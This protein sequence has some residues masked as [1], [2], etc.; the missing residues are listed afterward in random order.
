MN[1]ST[2]FNYFIN[3]DNTSMIS[4]SL[5][6]SEFTN[7]NNKLPIIVKTIMANYKYTSVNC[8]QNGLPNVNRN[9]KPRK[10]SYCTDFDL[11]LNNFYSLIAY[12][13]CKYLYMK[14]N[15]KAFLQKNINIIKAVPENDPELFVAMVNEWL[16]LCFGNTYK[17]NNEILKNDIMKT[18]FYNKHMKTN[19]MEIKAALLEDLVEIDQLNYSVVKAE[20]IDVL[21]ILVKAYLHKTLTIN[22]TDDLLMD[23]DKFDILYKGSF[24]KVITELFDQRDNLAYEKVLQEYE[25]SN[26]VDTFFKSYLYSWINTLVGKI[27]GINVQ[28]HFV[29]YLAEAIIHYFV[30]FG[31][32]LAK[33]YNIVLGFDKTSRIHFKTVFGCVLQTVPLFMEYT[34]TQLTLIHYSLLTKD[35]L[36]KSIN[37]IIDDNNEEH[38][39][40]D[41]DNTTTTA[42]KTTKKATKKAAKKTTKKK[43]ESED[44][45]DDTTYS[46]D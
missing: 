45:E 7:P 39:D 6:Q 43:V 20:T 30:V 42:K 15:M 4:K 41:G 21:E 8:Q 11:M 14:S 28:S 1:S 13:L 17:F 27:T 5:E 26:S 25:L 9:K 22:K 2:F 24:I 37:I 44:S 40:E 18:K 36:A 29:S 23:L 34:P 33:S 16:K 10:I 35:Q 3:T 46:E 38:D 19:P 12:E 32:N 31:F